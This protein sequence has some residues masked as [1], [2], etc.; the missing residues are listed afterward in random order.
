M[1]P[2]TRFRTEIFN[3]DRTSVQFVKVYNKNALILSGRIAIRPGQ[4]RL[5]DIHSF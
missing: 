4:G 3:Q 1:R 5:A 2:N